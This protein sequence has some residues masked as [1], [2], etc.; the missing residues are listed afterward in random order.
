MPQGSDPGPPTVSIDSC[1]TYD[2]S[3]ELALITDVYIE[4][5]S[6]KYRTANIR[7]LKT[8][9]I[10]NQELIIFH[11]NKELLNN[12]NFNYYFNNPT[13][14]YNLI[15]YR[16]TNTRMLLTLFKMFF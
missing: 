13:N 10:N 3:E 11:K 7:V 2:G 5:N 9:S 8:H 4:D 14:V 15:V 12:V 16:N 1:S 6:L